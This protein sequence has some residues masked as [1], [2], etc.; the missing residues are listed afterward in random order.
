MDNSIPYLRPINIFIYSRV[1]TQMDLDIM[2]NIIKIP[3]CV[4]L[5]T[6]R[7]QITGLSCIP[8]CHLLNMMRSYLR[9]DCVCVMGHLTRFILSVR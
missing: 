8:G 2:N 4:I 7:R 3:A 1:F 9:V 6:K 5:F